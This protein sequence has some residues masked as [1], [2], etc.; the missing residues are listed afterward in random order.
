MSKI[1]VFGSVNVDYVAQ[2]ERLPGP[3][4]T[5]KTDHYEALPGGKGANQALAAARNAARTSM[6][7]AIGSDG[8]EAVSLRQLSADGVDVSAV[9]TRDGAS[10]LAMIAVDAKGENQIVVVSG[11]NASAAAS[12][13]PKLA[14]SDALVTQNEISWSQTAAAHA[15]A[16]QTGSTVIHN[17]APAHAL[18]GA[19]L[20]NI[21][22]L[23]VN[24]HELTMAAPASAD[25][26]DGEKAN[27]LL[28]LGVG[29]V[30]L[31]LGAE[32]ACLYRA[33]A[34]PISV[35]AVPTAVVDT[36]GAG[37]AF[38]GALAAAI[39][40]GE[41]LAAGVATANA[42]AARVCGVMGAQTTLPG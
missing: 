37:D 29:A 3:G 30:V 38:V 33:G 17:A 15:A 5:I 24:E 34:D 21:D 42:Y 19:E 4:E 36:T 35:A 27:S 13:V 22:I 10:G 31:T 28:G 23:V 25:A 16:K 26:S 9:K 2:V 12:D 32:G 39:A 11:A 18:N 7:G 8:L 41:D 20:A 6:V 1:V 40:A 14:T